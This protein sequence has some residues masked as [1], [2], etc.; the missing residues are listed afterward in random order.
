MLGP[1]GHI[2]AGSG[3]GRV[4]GGQYDPEMLLTSLTVD[5]A[6]FER[7][8][9]WALKPEGACRDDVCIPLGDEIGESVDVAAV[10]DRMG[11]PIV[12][13]EDHSLWALGPWAGNARTLTGATAPE[14]VLPD[15]DGNE[16][17]L[18]SLRGSKVLIVAWAPY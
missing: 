1:D 4:A 5:R 13:D 8:T 14:L 15:V 11:L 18:S 10:A 12:H 9:G 2:V 7:G 16:F 6:A 3:C 17:D